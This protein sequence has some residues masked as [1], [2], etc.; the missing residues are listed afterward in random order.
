MQMDHALRVQRRQAEQEY[1]DDYTEGY[2]DYVPT[3]NGV[4][5]ATHP[6]KPPFSIFGTEQGLT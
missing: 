6:S 3:A 4:E 5:R 1:T 2:T